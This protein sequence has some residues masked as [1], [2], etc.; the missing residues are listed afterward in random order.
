[1]EINESRR[2]K[3]VAVLSDVLNR[4][5]ERNDRFIIN[6]TTVTRFHAL[7]APQIDIKSYL[8]RIAK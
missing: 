1:M 2:S 5:C 7:Q 3:L 4:L 8:D 6:Q